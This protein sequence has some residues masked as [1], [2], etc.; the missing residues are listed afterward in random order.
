MN[1]TL[2]ALS[3]GASQISDSIGSPCVSCALVVLRSARARI[4]KDAA[5][6]PSNG[7]LNGNAAAA[8]GANALSSCGSSEDS[9]SGDSS[10]NAMP[11]NIKV[12]GGG[13]ARGPE[14]GK[15]FARR[16]GPLPSNSKTSN[17]AAA[18]SGGSS[19]G[20]NNGG[21]SGGNMSASDGG[22]N[23]EQCRGSGD[24]NDP[25]FDRC[26]DRWATRNTQASHPAT[27]QMHMHSVFSVP[28]SL[29]A[30][31]PTTAPPLSHYAMH[32]QA[33]AAA[34]AAAYSMPHPPP[35]P[36][37]QLLHMFSGHITP[38]P[39]PPTQHGYFTHNQH[40]RQEPQ[41]TLNAQQRHPPQQASDVVAQ[42]TQ[43]APQKL[44]PSYGLDSAADFPPL[45][46]ASALPQAKQRR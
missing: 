6:P 5:A 1:C 17:G 4:F 15:S 16:R 42:T 23:A 43:A 33:A 21:V 38:L 18:V 20:G 39:P 44:A 34:A 7:A 28:P 30:H 40:R 36:P 45:S 12:V 26:Y 35:P 32:A 11:M 3:L 8:D 31:A 24:A 37:P 46:V 2:Y 29:Y 25:D 22:N 19:S 10:A 41:R 13:I 14:E 9:K 27:S